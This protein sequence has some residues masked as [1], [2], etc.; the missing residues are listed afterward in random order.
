MS[1]WKI[2][3]ALEYQLI[4][5]YIYDA[6]C[7]RPNSSVT[8]LIKFPFSNKCYDISKFYNEGFRQDLY[9]NL[10]DTIVDCFRQI[11]NNQKWYAFNWQHNCYSFIPQLPFEKNE[12]D[13]WLVPI[14]PN[15]DY[16]FFLSHNLEDGMF[17]N[18]IDMLICFFGNKMLKSIQN[19]KSQILSLSKEFFNNSAITDF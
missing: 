19:T 18:G 16:I 11:S 10:H 8:E 15:G 4:W 9:D 14:F 6:F 7:F 13:E 1:N 2:L 17:G 5:D 12:F 3:N